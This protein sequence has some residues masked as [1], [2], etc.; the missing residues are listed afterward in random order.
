MAR[1]AGARPASTETHTPTSERHDYRA[2][3]DDHA[4]IGQIGTKRLENGVEAGSQGHPETDTGDGAGQPDESALEYH[5]P[6][7]LPSRRPHSPQ[8]PRLSGALG[9][10]HRERVQDDKPTDEQGDVREHEQE[11]LY[12][13]EAA[14]KIAD[15]FGHLLGA[16]ADDDVVRKDPGQTVTELGRAHPAGGGDVYL[17]KTAGLAGHGLRLGQREDGQ[18]GAGKR[19]ATGKAHRAHQP[20]PPDGPSACYFDYVTDAEA[21]GC[22]RGH[23]NVSFAR[24]R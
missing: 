10:R 22:S 20:V 17:V 8:E 13:P 19:T 7:D 2:A 18:A 14:G 5:R 12:E 24:A 15:A 23:V 9:H 4:V 16:G 3:L 6:E 11:R 21:M 1:K